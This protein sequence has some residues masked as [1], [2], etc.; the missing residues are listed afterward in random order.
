MQG[1]ATTVVR[2]RLWLQANGPV[3]QPLCASER[4]CH[5]V[6][7]GRCVPLLM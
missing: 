3:S 4:C 1:C 2:C 7:V 5:H 6:Q